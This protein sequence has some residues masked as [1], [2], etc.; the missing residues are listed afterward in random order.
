MAHLKRILGCLT[1]DDD[2]IMNLQ[3]ITNLPPNDTMSHPKD[4]NP[5]EL[6]LSH[7]VPSLYR[8]SF[9]SKSLC[10]HLYSVL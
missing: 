5:H 8:Q 10:K 9:Q 2:C 7:S 6:P 3:N 4:M 1:L